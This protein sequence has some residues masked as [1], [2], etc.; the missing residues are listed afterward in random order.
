MIRKLGRQRGRP[1]IY[2]R[3]YPQSHRNFHDEVSVAAG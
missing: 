2:F 1:R 3:D